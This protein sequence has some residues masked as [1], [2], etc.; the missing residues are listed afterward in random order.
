MMKSS[1][2]LPNWLE[3]ALFVA[4]GF[5]MSLFIYAE[6][7]IGYVIAAVL[8]AMTMR[9]DWLEWRGDQGRRSL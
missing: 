2:C 1:V 7:M 3:R 9:N 8:V 4:F 6:T 5:V